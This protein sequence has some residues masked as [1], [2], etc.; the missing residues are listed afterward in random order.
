[1]LRG[2]DLPR[3]KRESAKLLLQLNLFDYYNATTVSLRPNQLRKFSMALSVI[4]E[5]DILLIDQP[6]A[7]LD[8]QTQQEIWSFLLKFRQVKTLIITTEN[9]LEAEVLADKLAIVY[10]G[11]LQCFGSPWYVNLVL[12]YLKIKHLF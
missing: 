4:G 2:F 5:V 10:K 12:I 9:S 8:V 6:T 11:S 7:G 1:M 3:A